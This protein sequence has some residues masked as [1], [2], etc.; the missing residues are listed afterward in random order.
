VSYLKPESVP[1]AIQILDGADF[2]SGVKVTVS[3]ARFDH[4][5]D[6][7]KKRKIDKRLIKQKM[8]L[9]EK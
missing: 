4:Q 1:L 5:G 9:M 2:R 7:K 6:N 3:E 8:Q